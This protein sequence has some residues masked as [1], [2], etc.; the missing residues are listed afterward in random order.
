M[1]QTA[2]KAIRSVH[3]NPIALKWYE[4]IT[5]I[6]PSVHQPTLGNDEHQPK[7]TGLAL[8]SQR[9]PCGATPSH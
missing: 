3:I 7:N 9:R 5:T 4:L 1:T 8:A 2:T 6:Q